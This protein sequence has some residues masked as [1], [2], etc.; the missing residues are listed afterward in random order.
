GTSMSA[1]RGVNWTRGENRLR[2]SGLA[3]MGDV[4]WGTHTGLFYRNR[5]DIVELLVPYFKA[6]LENNEYCLWITSEPVE[7]PQAQMILKASFAGFEDPLSRAQIEIV[8]HN[9]CCNEQNVFD[10]DAIIDF[11]IGRLERAIENGYSGMRVA[12]NAGWITEG[13]W[14]RLSKYEETIDSIIQARKMLVICAYP[15]DVCGPNEIVEVARNHKSVL[16]RREGEWES[17]ES[18]TH[19]RA[20]M[21]LAEYR[22]MISSL[23]SNVPSMS[24]R[25]ANDKEYTLEYASEGCRELTGYAPEDLEFNRRVSYGHVIHPDDRERV[26]NDIQEALKESKSF[27]IEYRIVTSGGDTKWVWEQGRGIMSKEGDILALEGFIADITPRKIAEEALRLSEERF[28]RLSENAQDMIFRMRLKPRVEFE[29]VNRASI[30]ILGYTPEEHYNDPSVSLRIIHPDDRALFES[31][32]SRDSGMVGPI[33]LRWIHK[34]GRVVW[35]EE[36][37]VPILDDSGSVIAVEGMIRDITDRKRMEDAIVQL[38]DILKLIN[39]TMRHDTLNELTVVSGALELYAESRN[40][41]YL[42]NA[43]RAVNRCVDL[44]RRMKELE[45]FVSAGRSL[46]PVK[47]RSVIEEVVR[48]YPIKSKIA[49]DATVL[50]DEA[51]SSVFDNIIRNAVVHGGTDRIDVK[52]GTK[53]DEF[54]VRVADHGSGIPANIKDKIFDEGF[55]YGERRG[56]GLGLHLVRKTVERYGGSVRVEDNK[57]RGAVFVLTFHG[58]KPELSPQRKTSPIMS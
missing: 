52:I 44:I 20:D 16:L 40:E 34:D 41:K 47:V 12:G 55:S 33:V 14:R 49:G 32:S 9:Q 36:R 6:G 13:E 10:A 7:A 46:T 21:A 43:L 37:A 23:L 25:C 26:W 15:I 54:E 22:Q 17:I 1:C 4:P 24:Y 53:G 3:V 56:T 30:S 5:D 31:V 39:K 42:D 2:K 29:Y 50:A 28:R 51:L 45:S 38:N 57:P 19:I 18:P 58:N 8:P 27:T 11:M 35:T 48:H